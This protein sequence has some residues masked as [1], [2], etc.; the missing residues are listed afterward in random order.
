MRLIEVTTTKHKAEFHK[1]Q[2]EL[3]KDNVNFV[4]PLEILVENI[5]TP[6]RNEFLSHGEA[7]RFLLA[8][9]GRIIGRVAVFI[10]NKKAYTYRQPTG[11]MG[12]FECINDREAAF[13]L[14]DACKQWLAARGMQAMDGPVNFGENDNYWGLLVEGYNSMPSFGMPYNMPYYKDFFEEYGFKMYFEQVTNLLRLNKNSCLPERIYRV[15]EWT[16]SKKDFTYKHFNYKH[17][18]QFVRDLKI[19][20]DKAWQF[21]DN[22]TP[23]DIRTLEKELREARSIIDPEMILFAYH[24]DEPIAFLIMFP[25]AGYIF[26]HFKG[27]LNLWNKLRFLWMKKHHYIK[28]TRITIMGVTPEYQRYGIESAMFVKLEEVMKKRPWIEAVELSWVGDFNPKMRAVHEGVGADFYQRHYTYRCLF[29]GSSDFERC[30]EIAVDTKEKFLQ[31][32]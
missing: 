2:R 30:I 8:D 25:D 17:A 18:S 6:S 29:D 19:V 16:L 4:A 14:F 15:A 22:F 26:K 12:F 7:T 1:F 21:H 11:G 31:G 27:R 13:I 3:Y 20:Y 24:N 23:I 32:V 28:R 10:N 5:F 9:G